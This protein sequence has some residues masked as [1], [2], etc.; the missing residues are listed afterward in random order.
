MVALVLLVCVLHTRL[1][2]WIGFQMSGV[3]S[4]CTGCITSSYL[5][6]VSLLGLSSFGD[7]PGLVLGVLVL[8]VCV[9]GLRLSHFYS[10]IVVVQW[11]GGFIWGGWS[12][13][14]GFTW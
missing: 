13:L 3:L 1:S 9:F 11:E 12:Y 14:C 5:T 4:W 7:F 8:F 6:E 10:F 2:L